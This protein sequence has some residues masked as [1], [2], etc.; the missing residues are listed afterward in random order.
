M[1]V[2]LGEPLNIPCVLTA[3]SGHTVTWHRQLHGS[4]EWETIGESSGIYDDY[5]DLYVMI[6]TGPTNF[7]LRIKSVPLKAPKFTCDYASI[8]SAETEI[9]VFGKGCLFN[10]LPLFLLSLIHS[11]WGRDGN[12]SPTIFDPKVVPQLRKSLPGKLILFRD[13]GISMCIHNIYVY[14]CISIHLSL[15]IYTPPDLTVWL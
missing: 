15:P 7:T 12:F 8:T 1:E 3:P 10:D 14:F 6:G 9:T 5:Q 11:T 4:S 2:L 13:L